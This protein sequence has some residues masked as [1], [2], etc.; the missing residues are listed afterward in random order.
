MPSKFP[1]VLL[2]LATIFSADATASDDSG[3]AQSQP[4]YTAAGIANSAA[5]VAGYYAPNSFLS[6]YGT[7]LS[8]V[9][10]SLGLGDLIGGQ[11]P[12]DGLI[13]GTEVGV[14]INNVPGYVFYVSP[15]QVNVLIPTYLIPGPVTLQLENRSVYGPPIQITLAAAAPAMFQLDASNVLATHGNGPVVT[16]AS[17]AQPGEI[18][19]LWATGLGFT[20]PALAPG[21][22][23]AAAARLADFTDFEV[24]LNGI[25]VDPGLIQYAGVA[26]GFAGLYQINVQLPADCPL[27]PEIQIG[28]GPVANLNLSPAQRFLP[29]E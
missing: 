24:Q 25:A 2:T 17:P 9:T 4:C 6:I 7:N 10:G 14:Y 11:L 16:P 28:F 22:I 18:V 21:E 20:I 12:A 26:P 8:Y 19:I 1:L 27:N 23:P 3:C 13:Q 5:N 15:A 29:V